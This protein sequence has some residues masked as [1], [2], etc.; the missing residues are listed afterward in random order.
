[1]SDGHPGFQTIQYGFAAYI[2]D[3]EHQPLPTGVA[4]LRMGMYR[5]L[6]FNNIENFLSCGFPVLKSVLETELWRDLVQDYFALHRNHTPLFIGIA[7]EFID[8]L[9]RERTPHPA[10]PPFLLELAHYEW[11]EL[12]LEVSEH[13][14]PP[15][16]SALLD[17]PLSHPVVLSELAWPLLYRYPVHQIGPAFQPATPPDRPTAV[18]VYRNRE[19]RVR[20]LEVNPVTFRLL[21]LLEAGETGTLDMHLKRLATELGTSSD[22]LLRHGV[23]LIRDWVMRGIVA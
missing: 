22:T 9:T 20:F 8:Y 10:D 21:E 4:P 19:D 16:N 12:A 5:E 1:M 6:F 2:R 13:E 11:V 7:E 17:N 15:V 14:P 23:E 3:P 18:L